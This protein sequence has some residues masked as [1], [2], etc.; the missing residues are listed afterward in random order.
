VPSGQRAEAHSREGIG[1]V[2][3][4][5]AAPATVV[6]VVEVVGGGAGHV[7]PPQASQQLGRSEMQAVPRLG[8]LQAALRLT[9]HVCTPAI[10][11]Q[12]VTKPGLPHV[13]VA[14]QVLTFPL[15]ARGRVPALAASLATAAAHL[16]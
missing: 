8:A 3:V 16:T 1:V 4:V 13:E 9:L 14:A 11:R 6:V 7:A 2:V 12:Q 5:G 15:H 10:V